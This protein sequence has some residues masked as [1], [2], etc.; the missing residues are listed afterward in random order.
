MLELC[1]VL[2]KAFQ[3]FFLMAENASV[4][5]W[6]NDATPITFQAENRKRLCGQAWQRY[7]AY[8]VAKTVGQAK[9]LHCLA[10]DF[11]QDYKHGLVAIE[12]VQVASGVAS[13]SGVAS[14]SSSN[15]GG[16]GSALPS[17]VEW[18]ESLAFN[19][20]DGAVL[21]NR[22]ERLADKGLISCL[23]CHNIAQGSHQKNVDHAS[24]GCVHRVEVNRHSLKQFMSFTDGRPKAPVQALFARVLALPTEDL[25]ALQ[26]QITEALARR[27]ESDSVV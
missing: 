27:R 3:F 21:F 9:A 19:A 8:K 6:S 26:V 17:F 1:K 25:E 14:R 11:H 2:V 24:T 18:V 13:S 10:R 15:V 4:I 12:Q 7:E 22:I 23:A 20:L 16:A 5:A